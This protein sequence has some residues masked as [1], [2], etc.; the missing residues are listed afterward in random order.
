MSSSFWLFFFCVLFFFFFCFF[1]CLSQ[2]HQTDRHFS[3]ESGSLESLC[4]ELLQSALR[5]PRSNAHSA[6]TALCGAVLALSGTGAIVSVI[7]RPVPWHQRLDNRRSPLI[8]SQ[9]KK[10][11]KTFIGVDNIT[12]LLSPRTTVRRDDVQ[13]VH[14]PSIVTIRESTR[15]RRQDKTGCARVPQVPTVMC[16]QESIT[17]KPVAMSTD[18]Q[19]T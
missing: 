5:L 10:Q 19:P 2:P 17:T 3:N 13:S 7:P 18:G 6:R 16:S 11:K 1:F 8:A 15:H 12:F 14:R 4:E 9:P